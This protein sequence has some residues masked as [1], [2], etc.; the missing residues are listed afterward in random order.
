MKQLLASAGTAGTLFCFVTGTLLLI[1]GLFLANN[2]H[3][4]GGTYI[5]VALPKRKDLNPEGGR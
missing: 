5:Q 2:Y 3:G 4:L 1:I